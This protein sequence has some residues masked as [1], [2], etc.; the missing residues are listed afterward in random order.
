MPVRRRFAPASLELE[1]ISAGRV[2]PRYAKVLARLM[3]AHALA[4]KLTAVGYQQALMT[5]EGP[6]LRSTIEKNA[7]EERRHAR[8]IYAALAEIGISEA[9]A[10][11]LMV[12]AAKGPSFAAPRGFADRVDD[13]IDLVMGSISLD[14]TGM[15]MIG[16]NYRDSS[17]GPHARA[18]ES[19]LDDEAEHESFGLEALGWIVDRFGPDRVQAALRT[20][21]PRAV[22]F[23][24]PPGSGFTFDCLTFG[25]KSRDNQELA[26]LYLAMIERRLEQLGLTRPALTDNYPHEAV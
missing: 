20:W 12:S 24:G 16:I 11:R 19:I 13:E 25:L 6:R 18:A 10:D 17:Y 1:D 8:M 15:L 21:L 14:A 26:D 7:A 22:N 4:E 23:F 5:I 3:A 2:E 9:Q